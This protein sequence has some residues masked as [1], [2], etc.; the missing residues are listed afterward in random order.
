M[1]MFYTWACFCFACSLFAGGCVS[2]LN[3]TD[4]SELKRKY[5]PTM[6]VSLYLPSK[7]ERLILCDSTEY[8][9]EW[10][11]KKLYFFMHPVYPGILMEPLYLINIE[12]IYIDKREYASYQQKSHYA[13][14]DKGFKDIE[15][16]KEITESEIVHPNGRTPLRCFRRDFKNEKTGDVILAAITYLDNYE[17]NMQYRDQD[18]EAIKQMLNSIKFIDED[19]AKQNSKT[20]TKHEAGKK[21][22]A[23]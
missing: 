22:E 11:C 18:V 9:G 16:H 10:N 5:F 14:A 19:C 12:V 20:E 1:K 17:G 7:T 23:K 6:N 3:R 13:S 15:F 21:P 4:I 8:K 2:G